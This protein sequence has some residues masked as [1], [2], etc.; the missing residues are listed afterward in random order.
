MKRKLFLPGTFDDEDIEVAE[1]DFPAK[2]RKR[3]LYLARAS[4]NEAT[5]GLPTSTLKDDDDYMAMVLPDETTVGKLGSEPPLESVP[6]EERQHFSRSAG[7]NKSLFEGNNESE[8]DNLIQHINQKVSTTL[9]SSKGLS[10]M[11]KMGFK[12]GDKLGRDSRS[13]EALSEPIKVQPS[14]GRLGIG[15]KQE[16]KKVLPLFERIAGGNR[17][18]TDDTATEYR[19]RV[20]RQKAEAKQKHTVTRLQKVCIEMAGNEE[21]Q[22][23][24][25]D[26]I[27]SQILYDARIKP[28]NVLWRGMVIDQIVKDYTNVSWKRLCSL[29]EKDAPIEETTKGIVDNLPETSS[30]AAGEEPSNGETQFP[31]KASDPE[32]LEFN[33]RPVEERLGELNVFLR[34]TFQYCYYCGVRYDDPDDLEENCPGMTEE[35][36][37]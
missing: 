6:F 27:R 8:P 20:T 10:M 31:A 29:T 18:I 16:I 5:K 37:A 9:T 11:E 33:S 28:I 26:D 21:A 7:M 34:E 36:H 14:R 35:D 30:D 12:V 3:L 23:Y 17:G 4:D 22:G 13:V 24:A 19:R 25:I 1:K 2:P 32:L 15:S